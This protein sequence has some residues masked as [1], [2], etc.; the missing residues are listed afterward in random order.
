MDENGTETTE[1]ETK[2]TNEKKKMGKKWRWMKTKT[3]R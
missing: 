1:I 2:S 3:K